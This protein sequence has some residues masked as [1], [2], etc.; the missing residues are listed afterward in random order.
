[1]PAPPLRTLSTRP[2]NDRAFAPG[3]GNPDE[4]QFLKATAGIDQLS[5]TND[6][7]LSPVSRMVF[8]KS[9]RKT[10]VGEFKLA[11][12]SDMGGLSSL[13]NMNFK[14]QENHIEGNFGDFFI[15]A[16]YLDRFFLDFQNPDDGDA[17]QNALQDA[18]ISFTEN[19]SDLQDDPFKNIKNHGQQRAQA[20]SPTTFDD[21]FNDCTRKSARR[22]KG[23]RYQEFMNHSLKKSKTKPSSFV[24]SHKSSS[25]FKAESADDKMEI[26]NDELTNVT[27]T[28]ISNKSESGEFQ[29][30]RKYDATNFNLDDKI[31]ALP[32][33]DLEEYLIKKKESKKKKKFS[34]K[35]CSNFIRSTPQISPTFR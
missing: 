27:E 28:Q 3:N 7:E 24:Q 8:Q 20:V 5:R 23:N 10:S 29:E 21:N 30:I 26:Q 11:N 12:E 32:G 17:L 15:D 13:L 4:N 33:L 19:Y 2:T 25:S 34:S 6:L 14:Q 31:M 9:S 16:G 18:K 1:M 22:G 35:F